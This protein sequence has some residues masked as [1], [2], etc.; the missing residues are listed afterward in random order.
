M[1]GDLNRHNYPPAPVGLMGAGQLPMNFM[2]GDMMIESQDVDM[3]ILGLDMNTWFD[4]YST[5]EMMQQFYGNNHQPPSDAN[6]TPGA[7]Q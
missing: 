5:P 1:N 3:S 2:P 7:G 6:G 4:P